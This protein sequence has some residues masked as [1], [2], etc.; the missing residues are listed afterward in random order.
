MA[1]TL[2]NSDGTTPSAPT[3]PDTRHGGESTA[4]IWS[5]VP[6]LSLVRG[7]CYAFVMITSATF[8]KSIGLQNAV[9]GY[10]SL[11]S[12]PASLK[13][14]WAPVADSYGKKR[15]WALAAGYAHVI[16][17]SAMALILLREPLPVGP[18]IFFFALSALVYGISDFAGDGFFV[19]AVPPAARS[20]GIVLLTA[21][22]RGSIALLSGVIFCAGFFSDHLHSLHR[23]WAAALGVLSGGV[24]LL[25]TYN[26][27][28][29]PRPAAD[30]PVRSGGSVPWRKIFN[31]Y[32]ETPRFWIV[33]A[34]LLTLRLGENLVMRM[35][36]VF[37]VEGRDRGGL[38]LSL[39]QISF[40]GAASLAAMITGGVL[41]M[42][43]IKR[44]GV[45]RTMI[46]LT[47]AM[48]V[49]NALYFLLAVYPCYNGI[50]IP[51][52]D[53][54]W[55]ISQV[56]IVSAV[57]CIEHLGYGLG[58]T[59]YFS[60]VVALSHGTYRASHMAFGNAVMLLGV[61]AP[62]SVG[63]L[64]QQIVGWPILFLIALLCCIPGFCLTFYLPSAVVDTDQPRPSA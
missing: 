11:L 9:I 6:T 19:C 50:T 52:G 62:N 42:A 34:Y 7:F 10:L 3:V 4:S 17:V 60:V 47:L 36:Q 5:Y 45:R 24:F 49:P 8:F 35:S 29:L 39:Q 14:L 33:M 22:S 18:L 2:L 54:S 27:F 40:V 61:I 41:S 58:F 59:F 16:C 26:F 12:L 28:A 46:P 13:F 1:S 53:S 57:H 31:S 51:L 43:I 23:G 32:R 37:F 30:Q 21:F 15:N 20:A 38:G 55:Q 64:V 63:G 48:L 44:F 25:T 56:A